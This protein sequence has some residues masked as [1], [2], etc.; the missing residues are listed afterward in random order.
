MLARLFVL[1]LIGCSFAFGQTESE[2]LA[3]GTILVASEKLSDPNFAQTVILI[4]RRESDG[5]I[6]GLV[7][8]RPLNIT[9]AK[10]FPQLHAGTDPVYE[11]GPVSPDAVLALLKSADKPETAELITADI[12]SVIRKNLLEKSIADHLGSSKFRVYLGYAGWGPGQLENE[13]RLGAWTIIHSP[14]YVF[15]AKPESLWDRLNR[16]LHTNL[17]LLRKPPLVSN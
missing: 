14:K 3:A 10:A 12:Y 2:H 13:L 17:A 15:D 4:T 9:L 6:M 7:L 1:T 11:G 16:D 5:G 8:N